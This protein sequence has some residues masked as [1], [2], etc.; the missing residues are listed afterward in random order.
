VEPKVEPKW[1]YTSRKVRC[2]VIL[3][4]C[5]FGKSYYYRRLWTKRSS[6]WSRW[7]DLDIHPTL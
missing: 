7:E 6:R 3:E 5:K 1:N 4:K 2:G